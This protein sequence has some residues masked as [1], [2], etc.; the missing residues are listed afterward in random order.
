MDAWTVLYRCPRRSENGALKI[1][2][3]NAFIERRSDERKTETLANRE[4]SYKKNELID[5][6]MFNT[7]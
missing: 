3:G 5:I 4:H 2:A 6:H 1:E 7:A